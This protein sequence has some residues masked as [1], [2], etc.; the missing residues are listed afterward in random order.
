MTDYLEIRAIIRGI[1]N[2]DNATKQ[3]IGR[4]FAV[5]LGL[6]PGPLGSDDGID[7]MGYHNE[8][9]IHFQCRLRDSLLDKDDARSYYSDIEYHRVDISVMLAGIGYK[10]TFTARLFGHNHIS[11]YKIHLLTIRD[12]FEGTEAFQEALQDLPSLRDLSRVVNF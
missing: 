4:R 6:E 3:E 11:N 7:G 12:L 5:H 2:C 10:D 8:R 9:K 1:V